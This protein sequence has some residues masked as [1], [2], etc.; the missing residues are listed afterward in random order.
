MP[1]AIARGVGYP[2]P[3]SSGGLQSTQH[4]LAQR[5]LRPAQPQQATSSQPPGP[6][7]RVPVMA[8]GSHPINPGAVGQRVGYPPA[9]YPVGTPQIQMPPQYPHSR[10]TMASQR[11]WQG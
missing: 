1:S 10:A 8:P 4:D 3:P 7:A 2:S 6:H 11:P 9:G 5:G